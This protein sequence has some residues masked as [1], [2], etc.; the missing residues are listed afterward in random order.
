MKKYSLMLA[1]CVSFFFAQSQVGIGTTTPDDGSVLQID[2]KVGA[3]VPPRMTF[4]EM[5]AIP[6]PLDGALVFN[7]THNTY[8]VYRNGFWS[9][10]TNASLILN[11]DYPSGNSAL[12][13]P[14]DTYV[15]FP[16]GPS[17][18]IAI[19]SS[20]YDVTANGTVT[21]KESGNYLFS[22]SLSTS[23]MPSGSK[24]Y[25][26]ALNVNGALVAYLS[27]GAS[28]LTSPDYWGISGTVMYPIVAN[29]VVTMR[30]V[31]N[32]GNTPINAKF[33]NIGISHLN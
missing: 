32:N 30:Y 17:D 18:I 33:V 11:K 8:F 6:T 26:I 20:A 16:I 14:N 31:L 1:L 21:I 23:N 22:A 5:S 2:S 19:N 27:R 10:Q 7:T 12:S 13:T 3:F 9:S 4:S 15:D 25:I 29:D 28:S 24:K